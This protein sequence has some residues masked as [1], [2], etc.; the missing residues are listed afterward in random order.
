MPAPKHN[1]PPMIDGAFGLIANLLCKGRHL[2][3]RLGG[4]MSQLVQPLL[5]GQ[6]PFH[7][8]SQLRKQ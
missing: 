7:E 4:R 8:R 3:D 1:A 5:N 6:H 2:T